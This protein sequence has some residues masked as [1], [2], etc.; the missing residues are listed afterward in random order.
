MSMETKKSNSW[1]DHVKKYKIDNN[2]SYADA[3]KLAKDTYVKTTKTKVKP[4]KA[5]DNVDNVDNVD[6]VDSVDSVENVNSVDSID[7]TI[8]EKPVKVKP[9]RKKRIIKKC[10]PNSTNVE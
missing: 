3:M 5:V 1:V 6:S 8:I 10:V 9:I 4:A 7:S 2:C